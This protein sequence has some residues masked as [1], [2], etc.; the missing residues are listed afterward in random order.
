LAEDVADKWVLALWSMAP[1]PAK[2]A[3]LRQTTMARHLKQHDIRKVDAA[4]ALGIL[5][6]PAIMVAPGVTEAE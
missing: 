3:C 2:A 6:Q 5:R 1:T 4:T